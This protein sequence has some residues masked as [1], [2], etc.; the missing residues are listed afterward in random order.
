[1]SNVDLKLRVRLLLRDS[2]VLQETLKVFF[3]FEMYLFERQEKRERE[4]KIVHLLVPKMASTPRA[5]LIQNQE[6]G[7]CPCECRGPRT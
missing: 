7:A 2:Q 5:E 1:M 3:C 6:Q 4:R